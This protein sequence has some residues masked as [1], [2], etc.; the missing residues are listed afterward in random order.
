MRN[1]KHSNLNTF[2]IRTINVDRYAY[3]AERFFPFCDVLAFKT[4]CAQQT[5]SFK[6]LRD[7][8]LLALWF[9]HSYLAITL[10]EL[11]VTILVRSC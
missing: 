7:K 5:N 6:I 8:A 10:S 1:V 3:V 4:R 11:R 9:A 2:F